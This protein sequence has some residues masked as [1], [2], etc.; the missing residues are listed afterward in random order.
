MYAWRENQ[1]EAT[2]QPTSPLPLAFS[3]ERVIMARS[4]DESLHVFG[5]LHLCK[6][7]EKYVCT[8]LAVL[9]SGCRLRGADLLYLAVGKE[10]FHSRGGRRLCHLA[11]ASC[12]TP[13]HSSFSS[14]SKVMVYGSFD[15]VR[16]VPGRP[17]SVI[18]HGWIS[19]A[20]P[21]LAMIS[22]KVFPLRVPS[23]TKS[24]C[25]TLPPDSLR[26]LIKKPRNMPKQANPIILNHSIFL[27]YIISSF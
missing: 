9:L 22:F 20:V 23:D 8:P 17:V 15:H 24:F 18:V 26:P 1:S 14:N 6:P 5:R 12:F 10:D 2:L 27:N 13:R 11:N 25:S 3:R 21:T 19:F 16:S 4:A 7:T